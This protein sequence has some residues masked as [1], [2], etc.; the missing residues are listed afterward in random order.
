MSL[1]VTEIIMALLALVAGG[2]GLAW[3]KSSAQKDLAETERDNVV[4]ELKRQQQEV[5]VQ[6][7]IDKAKNTVAAK[8]NG[9]IDNSLLNDARDRNSDAN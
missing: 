1:S 8:S 2:F 5:G 7:A 6:N 3:R 9:D 4:N